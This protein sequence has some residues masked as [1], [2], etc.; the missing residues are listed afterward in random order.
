MKKRKKALRLIAAFC[1]AVTAFSCAGVFVSAAEKTKTLLSEPIETEMYQQSKST[2]YIQEPV[3]YFGGKVNFLK[4]SADG[5]HT[6]WKFK[7]NAAGLDYVD[8]YGQLLRD[9]QNIKLVNT[10]YKNYPSTRISSGGTFFSISLDYTGNAKVTATQTDPYSNTSSNILIYGDITGDSLNFRVCIPTSMETVDFGYR[11]GQKGGAE[12]KKLGGKSASAGLYK[13]ADGSF[14]TSD[15]RLKVTLGKARVRTDGKKYTGTAVSKKNE[16]GTREELWIKS[17][18]GS[19][20]LLFFN[21]ADAKTGDV[22]TL[23]DL[24]TD[25]ESR[26]RNGLLNRE[27]MFSGFNWTLCLGVGYD[28]EYYTPLL[29]KLN[30]FKDATVRVMYYKKNVEAVYYIYAKMDD[31]KTFEVL[32]AVDLSKVTVSGEESASSGNSFGKKTCEDCNG[33]GKCRKCKGKGYVYK[34]QIGEGMIE[35]DCTYCSR[36]GICPECNGKREK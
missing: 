16:R 36:S 9:S 11:A 21:P 13:C 4:K 29:G 31:G 6:N 26:V 27:E 7:G 10:Y 23:D 15:N 12:S 32:C 18:N 24:K 33:S 30:Q 14:V 28:R 5:R 3:S 19:E 2:A 22:Y 8:L 17:F 1:A 20:V 25:N 34:M 35:Q